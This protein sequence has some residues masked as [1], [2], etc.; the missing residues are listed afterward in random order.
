MVE[1]EAVLRIVEAGLVREVH[2]LAHHRVVSEGLIGRLVSFHSLSVSRPVVDEVLHAVLD[3]IVVDGLGHVRAGVARVGFLRLDPVTAGVHVPDALLPLRPGGDQERAIQLS[4]I[5]AHPDD[6]GDLQRVAR[7]DLL[8]EHLVGMR[9]RR[10][11]AG[12]AAYADRDANGIVRHARLR[13]LVHDP[14]RAPEAGR[15]G[16]L[17]INRLRSPLEQVVARERVDLRPEVHRALGELALRLVLDDPAPDHDVV[18]VDEPGVRHDGGHL[19]ERSAL[20]ALPLRSLDLAPHVESSGTPLAGEN[21]DLSQPVPIDADRSAAVTELGESL[22]PPPVEIDGVALD[23]LTP[24]GEGAAGMMIVEVIAGSSGPPIV[25]ELLVQVGVEPDER[26]IVV[27]REEAGERTLGRRV[28]EARGVDDV[29]PPGQEEAAV[30]PS[31]PR[32]ALQ[33]PD[34]RLVPGERKAMKVGRLRK[35]G[36]AGSLLPTQ[37]LEAVGAAL[38]PG[39]RA[40]VGP[41]RGRAD[42][43]RSGQAASGCRNELAAAPALHRRLL[44]PGFLRCAR[45]GALPS[46]R[47]ERFLQ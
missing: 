18:D 32:L 46:T 22:A 13:D 21:A 9:I 8:P 19:A 7:L 14:R 41:E 15:V 20:R 38:G 31:L 16:D 34:L 26:V 6:P 24:V 28:E 45:T 40:F 27:H 30:D 47:A 35:V 1:A 12:A 37:Q 3:L 29:P 23:D 17:P 5:S 11:A 44:S 33:L 36:P 43:R 4:P 2:A 39:H 25:D 42:D 10:R